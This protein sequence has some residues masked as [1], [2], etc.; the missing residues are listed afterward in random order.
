MCVDALVDCSSDN[1][2]SRRWFHAGRQV[3]PSPG[4]VVM[5]SGSVL[6]RNVTKEEW[7]G[8]WRC[9]VENQLGSKEVTLNL[10]VFGKSIL[11]LE[12]YIFVSSSNVLEKVM[13]CDIL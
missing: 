13:K 12:F 5:S 3:F 9:S 2:V 7:G 1:F 8:E 11:H 10:V 6:L 4:R